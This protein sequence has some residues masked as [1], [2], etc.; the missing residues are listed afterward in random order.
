[1]SRL[2][3]FALLLVA[4][5]AAAQRIEVTPLASAGY[6]TAASIDKKTTGVQDLDVVGGFTWGAQ[7][8]WFFSDHVGV[9][10]LW[11][12][13]S[14]NVTLTTA[15]GSARLLDMNVDQVLGNLVYQWGTRATPFRP[16]VFAGIG[17]A[18]LSADDYETDR[19][20]AWTVGAGLKW[21]PMTRI[22]ARAHVRYKPTHVNDSAS[23]FCAPFGFCQ[24]TLQQME[25]AG[26]L[27]LRF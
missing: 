20:Q 22:G 25:F 12:R 27:V 2:I 4:A 16:F 15:T 11:T 7:G 13:Q 17:S 26:G 3:A 5:P 24:S 10:V 1:M 21:F 8:A 19:S 14:T 23:S 18:F 9:E 6:S